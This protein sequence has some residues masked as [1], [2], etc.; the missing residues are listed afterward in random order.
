MNNKQVFRLMFV[1]IRIVSY[2]LIIYMVCSLLSKSTRFMCSWNEK[3]GILCPSC[4]ATRATLA[5]IKGN[6]FKAI[7]YNI[8]YTTAI[9]PAIVFL[10]LDDITFIFLRLFK[11]TK[12]RSLIEVVLE[13]D[14]GDSSV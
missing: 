9:F 5:I 6:L 2:I 12:K 4:G 13:V 3:Y 1:V 8:V 11:V 14:S 10:I 7:E